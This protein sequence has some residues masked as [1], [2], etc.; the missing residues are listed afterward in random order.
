MQAITNKDS[1][2]I[3]GAP[4]VLATDGERVQCHLCGKWFQALNQHIMKKHRMDCDDYRARFG[5]NWGASLFS[6]ALQEKHRAG[7]T[8][9]HEEA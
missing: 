6:P 2:R 3:F 9:H 4:G 8:E 5:L 7:Q 1:G